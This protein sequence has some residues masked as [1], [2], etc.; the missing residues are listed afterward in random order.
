M[1]VVPMKRALIIGYADPGGPITLALQRA[2]VIQIESSELIEGAVD[3]ARALELAR[4]EGAL[5]DRLDDAGFVLEFLRRYRVPPKR[6]FAS[7]VTEKFHVGLTEF[8]AIDSTL[9]FD[10]LL[11]LC[12]RLEADLTDL[13]RRLAPADRRVAELGRWAWVDAPLGALRATRSTRAVAYGGLERRLEDFRASLESSAPAA[14][15]TRGDGMVVVMAHVSELDRVHEAA[16]SNGLTDL[17]VPAGSDT[18]SAELLRA[19][20]A[21]EEILEQAGTV[22]REVEGLTP[23][24]TDV[25]AVCESARNGLARIHARQRFD[26]TAHAVFI[27]GWV[28]ADAVGQLTA[29][30]APFKEVDVTLVDPL[31]DENPP[32][33][34][35]NPGWLE[36]FELLTRLYGMP[37]YHELDPTPLFAPFFIAFF[38]ITVG[39]VGYGLMLAVTGWLIL[40]YLDIAENAKRFM[41]LMIYG[42]VTA[43]VA[44]V[45][46]GGWFAVDIKDLPPAL[47]AMV[48][49][50]PLGQAMV[51]LIFT[52]LLG[53]TQISWGL[54][55]EAWD[56]IRTGDWWAAVRDQGTSLTVLLA[57]VVAFAGWIASTATPTVP[58]ALAVLYPLSLRALALGAA[59]VTLLTGGFYVP[60][61][62]AWHDGEKVPSWL[63][64]LVSAGLALVVTAWVLG[65]VVGFGVVTWQMLLGA[66]AVALA[67]SKAGRRMVV[68]ALSGMYNLYGM[69]AYIG[70]VLSYA[71]LMA[72]GLATVLI[73]STVNMMAKM[74]FAGAPRL[75]QGADAGALA[76]FVL[77]FLLASVGGLAILVLGHTFNVVINLLGSFVHPMRL[78]F[79]EF[80]G[81]FYE[82]SGKQFK[83]LTYTTEALVLDGSER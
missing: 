58:A 34:I 66:I 6:P 36:P 8:E 71:R 46:T 77:L 31:P 55:V 40:R 9:N 15:A 75:P 39:D 18:P 68:G 22:R 69:S 7:F 63:D 74:V 53:V 81:K 42:G 83:P 51:F 48:V 28:R 10:H 59:G 30:L 43:M 49:L 67:L 50:D 11:A 82:G 60:A 79:V 27:Q 21:R 54:V 41:R 64:R 76:G 37:D 5:A 20:Q 73:G 17:P 80:F 1:A 57:S 2:G 26:A 29:A 12:R 16:R 33:E 62:K 52:T 3:E 23:L 47:K 78:Q 61:V 65:G 19:R 44:G 35:K 45:L 72:L 14:E 56:S 25:L 32:V 13:E 24:Y 38:G 4:Q 70:D